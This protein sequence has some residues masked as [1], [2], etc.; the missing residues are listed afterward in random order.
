MYHILCIAVESQAVNVE[1]GNCNAENTESTNAFYLT[2][3]GESMGVEERHWNTVI[4]R[5]LGLLILWCPSVMVLAT[6]Y[7]TVLFH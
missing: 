2:G 4:H 3:N 7:V 5:Q 6:H 1:E